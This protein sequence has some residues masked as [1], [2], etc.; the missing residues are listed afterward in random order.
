MQIKRIKKN[1][2]LF[3]ILAIIS[4]TFLLLFSYSTSSLYESYGYDSAI[5]MVMGKSIAFGKQMYSEIF[6]HKG[7][8]LFFIQFIGWKIGGVSGI[9][10]IQIINLTCTLYLIYKIGILAKLNIK[11]IIFLLFS[12]LSLIGFT[13]FEGNQSEEYC[14]VFLLIPLSLALRYILV[15]KSFKHPQI[16]SFIYGCCFCMV[17][18][19]RL[20]NGATIVG[21]VTAIL[22]LLIYKKEWKN[23]IQNIIGF[24]IGFLVVMT[25]II[26]H[27]YY[28]DSLYDMLYGTFLYNLKYTSH[29]DSIVEKLFLIKNKDIFRFFVRAS[30]NILLLGTAI[31][32]YARDGLNIKGLAIAISIAIF[33]Y[34][35]VNMGL[36]SLHY[37]TINIISLTLGLILLLRIFTEKNLH[38][39]HF[40]KYILGIFC[41][42]MLSYF[43]YK[44]RVAY[45]LLTKGNYKKSEL[46]G[47]DYYLDKNKANSLIK[48]EDRDSVFGYNLY[49][50]WYLK[51]NIIPPYKYFTNQES[52]IKADSTIYFEINK[53]LT[54]TPPKWIVIP[55]KELV[56]WT[57]GIDSNPI[58][59]NLLYNDYLLVDN[60]INHDY[61]HRKY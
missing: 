58:L 4:T 47:V 46:L 6:D 52:W 26:L 59:K 36:N 2:L 10:I 43:I 14:L 1:G 21:I 60:D 33:S 51:M 17:A 16:Y 19:N 39:S 61:Y 54:N 48:T 27:F 34:I 23:I 20:S 55:S 30:P 13:N 41:I 38:I 11:Q 40:E 32:L 57:D 5:F 56:S 12:A 42:C 9:F 22:L 28:Y 44:D 49:A 8:I 29:T 53:Y 31:V 37:A 45:Q 35:A 7:P 50:A 15:D 18:F 24:S 25:P 3:I